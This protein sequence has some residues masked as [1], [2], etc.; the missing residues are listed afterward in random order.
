MCLGDMRRKSESRKIGSM[1]YSDIRQIRE[2]VTTADTTAVEK[3][4]NAHLARGWVLL[5]VHQ[6]NDSNG[7][8]HLHTAYI[9][10]HREAEAEHSEV[11]PEEQIDEQD[12]PSR[13]YPA[14]AFLW[15]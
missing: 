11:E 7:T 14:G 2:I 3:L 8:T 12:R 5:S 9:L 6:R 10:G 4:V 15:G 13:P 1:N